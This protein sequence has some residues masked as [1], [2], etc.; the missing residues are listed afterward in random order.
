MMRTFIPIHH[1][2]LLPL[3]LFPLLLR[4]PTILIQIPLLPLSL[5][6]KIMAELAFPAL[7][8]IALLVVLTQHRLRI[9]TERHFLNLHRFEEIGRFTFGLIR[10]GF[11]LFA[12]GFFGVFTFLF[13]GFGRGGLGFYGL[14]LFLG[15]GSFFLE[16]RY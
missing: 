9:H 12:L 6:R 5:H 15:L 7:F 16:R 13:G 10:G 4:I 8:A 3:F 1:I 11:F 14:D 2:I